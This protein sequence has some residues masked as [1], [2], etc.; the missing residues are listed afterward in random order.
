M[1]PDFT[2]IQPPAAGAVSGVI[3]AAGRSRRMGCFKPLLPFRG[4]P[5]LEHVLAAA[6]ESDLTPLCVVLGLRAAE[7]QA[8]VDMDGVEVVV[9]TEFAA[10]QAGSLA[11]GLIQVESRCTAAMFLLGDQPLVTPRLIDSL[12]HAHRRRTAAITLPIFQ[13]RRGNP[14]IV[15]A[16]LFPEL[17]R[18]EGDTGARALFA[19]HE[20]EIQRVA[21]EDPAVLLDVDHPSD[22]DRLLAMEVERNSSKPTNRPIKR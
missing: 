2:D 14:V 20:S 16:R 22:Y 4:R 1:A 12:I 7:I 6:R 19:A 5:L 10:G 21:V 18:I 3:L 11:A 17:L 15:A 8:E 13:G 9:N